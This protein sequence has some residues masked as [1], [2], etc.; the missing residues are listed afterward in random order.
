M[1]RL[2]EV[3]FLFGVGLA[4]A[5]VDDLGYGGKQ[6][7]GDVDEFEAEGGSDFDEGI[8]VGCYLAAFDVG[9]GALATAHAIAY[10]FLR[11]IHEFAPE[12]KVSAQLL[13]A[14]FHLLL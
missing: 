13:Q 14:I 8:G 11:K 2:L 10:C 3:Q 12:C 6:L 7:P 4:Q 5:G 1:H 9:Y